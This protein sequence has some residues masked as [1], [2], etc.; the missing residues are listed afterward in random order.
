V[1]LGG[2]LVNSA[3]ERG[4]FAETIAGAIIS[5]HMGEGGDLILQEPPQARGFTGALFDHYGGPGGV[6]FTQEMEFVATDGNEAAGGGLFSI[7]CVGELL[8]DEA[9]EEQEGGDQENPFA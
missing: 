7:A 4:G 6:T 3:A 5:T 8:I 2:A 1:K 9:G